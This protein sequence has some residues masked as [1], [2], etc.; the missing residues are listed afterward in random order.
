MKDSRS[1]L[2]HHRRRQKGLV[3][4]KF[5]VSVCFAV[6]VSDASSSLVASSQTTP[7]RNGSRWVCSALHKTK[8]EPKDAL[9]SFLLSLKTIGYLEIYLKALKDSTKKTRPSSTRVT[10]PLRYRE[11]CCCRASSLRMDPPL[12][13]P[14]IWLWVCIQGLQERFKSCKF[15]HLFQWDV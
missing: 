13:S 11:E 15:V 10:P 12:Y 6:T 3:Y 5:E 9:N 4:M 2:V 14:H 1:K 8:K 7:T